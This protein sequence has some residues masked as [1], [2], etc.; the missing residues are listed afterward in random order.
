MRYLIKNGIGAFCNWFIWELKG[1]SK[2]MATR[3]SKL[4]WRR[5]ILGANL[6]GRA[7]SGFRVVITSYPMAVDCVP[8]PAGLLLVGSLF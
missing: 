6:L 3:G 1:F 7:G 8:G 5:F 4:A 2:Q